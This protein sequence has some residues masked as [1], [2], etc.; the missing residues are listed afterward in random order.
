MEE[1]G[2]GF[3]SSLAVESGLPNTISVYQNDLRQFLA[4]RGTA[5][6]PVS[7]WDQIDRPLFSKYILNL[8]GRTYRKATL[9]RK[10]A[11]LKSFFNFLAEEGII[12]RDP[13]EELDSAKPSRRAEGVSSRGGN[14]GWAGSVTARGV[15]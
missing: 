4:Q 11:A 10:V 6:V 2:Q 8:R 15:S 13:T 5:R 3:L 12:S 14:H 1:K 9:A 7:Q